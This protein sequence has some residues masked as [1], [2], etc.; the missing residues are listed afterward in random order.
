MVVVA[1]RALLP[2]WQVLKDGRRLVIG[3]VSIYSETGEEEGAVDK[4]RPVAHAT[5]TYSTPPDV[6]T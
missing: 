3:R 1:T 5:L 4:K 6:A 2:L